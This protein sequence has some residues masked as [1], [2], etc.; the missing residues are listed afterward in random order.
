MLQYL[1]LRKIEEAE[2]GISCAKEV[3][4]VVLFFE[5]CKWAFD[6]HAA[7]ADLVWLMGL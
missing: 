4:R 5:H 2:A 1:D 3:L 6:S 7:T